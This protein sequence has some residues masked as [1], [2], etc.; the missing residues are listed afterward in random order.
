MFLQD[1]SVDSAKREQNIV[2]VQQELALFNIEPH[3]NSVF[4]VI[5]N[6]IDLIN[7]KPS[8]HEKDRFIEVYISIKANL[9]LD[10]LEQALKKQLNLGAGEGDFLARNRHLSYLQAAQ[11]SVERGLSQFKSHS[12]SELLAEDLRL[13][14]DA[15]GKITGAITSDELLGEIFSSFCIGK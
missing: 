7:E 14:Q 3:L 8:L 6:K 9:G 1:V 15:L 12:A 5:N 4:F 2:D 10:L 13:A 11:T